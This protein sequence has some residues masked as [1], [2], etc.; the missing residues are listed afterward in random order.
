MLGSGQQTFQVLCFLSSLLSSD[1]AFGFTWDMQVIQGPPKF[2]ASA[3]SK[4]LPS[5]TGGTRSREQVANS[6]SSRVWASPSAQNSEPHSL[7][8]RCDFRYPFLT[9]RHL[10]QQSEGSRHRA[11]FVVLVLITGNVINLCASWVSARL[12]ATG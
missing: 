8:G 12:T 5:T 6:S 1:E 3:V 4:Q 11:A 9:I 7:S 10:Q 2:T